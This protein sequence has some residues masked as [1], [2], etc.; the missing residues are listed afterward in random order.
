MTDVELLEHNTNNASHTQLRLHTELQQRGVRHKFMH[1]PHDYYQR[2]LVYRKYVSTRVPQ[3][4]T[5]ACHQL[6]LTIPR[7]TPSQKHAWGS[8]CVSFM[9]KPC[10]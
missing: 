6:T 9:Q 4:H 5:I 2:D 3:T 1:A 10:V 7:C 8:V